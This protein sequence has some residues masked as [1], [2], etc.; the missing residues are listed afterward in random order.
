MPQPGAK[1]GNAIPPYPQQA[2]AGGL[3]TVQAAMWIGLLMIPLMVLCVDMPWGLLARSHLNGATRAAAQA[4]ATYCTDLDHLQ[5]TGNAQLGGS[6]RTRGNPS[7]S[8]LAR[9]VITNWE[10]ERVTTLSVNTWEE[11]RT[12]RNPYLEARCFDVVVR[13]SSVY[14]SFFVGPVAI[15]AQ[16][17]SQLQA[18]RGR[19]N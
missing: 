5:Q 17:R 9:D 16:S 19:S 2:R 6:C 4:V 7:P 15:Q 18:T 12:C 10:F 8:A 14:A 13:A 11:Q 3:F 1:A